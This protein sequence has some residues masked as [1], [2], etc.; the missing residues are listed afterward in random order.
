MRKKVRDGRNCERKKILRLETII[1]GN[2]NLTGQ[3][4]VACD[5]IHELKIK[6]P[7]RF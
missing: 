5:Y 2:A 1:A 3:V 4:C 6:L 7:T